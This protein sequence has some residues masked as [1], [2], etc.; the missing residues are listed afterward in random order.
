MA[1]IPVDVPV[2]LPPIPVS[3][4]IVGPAI[5]YLGE[6][7]HAVW[8]DVWGFIKGKAVPF[9]QNLAGDAAGIVSTV[10]PMVEAYVGQEL[11]AL[12]GFINQA[13]QYTQDIGDIVNTFAID[14]FTSL[15]ETTQGIDFLVDGLLEDVRGIETGVIPSIEALLGDLSTAID[16]GID[17]VFD[18]GKTWAIDNI[19][20]PLSAL[21]EQARTDLVDTIEGTAEGTLTIV[22]GLIDDATSPLAAEIA[23]VAAAALTITTWVDDCG[24]PMCEEFGP[25]SDLAPLL[26]DLLGSGIL[27]LLAGLALA[28]PNV[29]EKAA[30]VFARTLGPALEATVDDWVIPLQA[31]TADATR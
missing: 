8:N 12:S 31:D 17:N 19:L 5:H 15:T 3:V 28:D 27:A 6:G 25:A 24:V 14:A 18:L 30:L 9:V 7:E 21:L 22:R 23:A 16:T 11:A 26:K 20:D 13:F 1:L 29:D 2:D 4:P 10:V